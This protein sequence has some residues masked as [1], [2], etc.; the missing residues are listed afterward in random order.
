MHQL[1]DTRWEYKRIGHD[2][3]PITFLKDGRVGGRGHWERFEGMPVTLRAV[4]WNSRVVIAKKS[5]NGTK[6]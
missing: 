2:L 4:Q 5:Q 3:R 1:C 6:A